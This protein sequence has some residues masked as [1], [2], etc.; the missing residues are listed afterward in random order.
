MDHQTEDLTSCNN[1]EILCREQ[2]EKS[3]LYAEVSQC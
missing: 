3:L 1:Q 2:E